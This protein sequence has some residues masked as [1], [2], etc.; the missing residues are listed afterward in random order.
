M[1]SKSKRRKGLKAKKYNLGGYLNPNGDPT[2]K[3]GQAVAESTAVP[4]YAEQAFL[5]YA[6]LLPQLQTPF[7]RDEGTIRPTPENEPSFLQSIWE[8]TPL[9]MTEDERFA[10]PDQMSLLDVMAEPMK[11]IEYYSIESNRGKL[12]TRAEWDLFGSSNPYDAALAMY[13]PAA[14]ISFAKEDE[15][16][17]L[18]AFTGIGK[19]GNVVRDAFNTGDDLLRISAENI[20]K[21]GQK[22][23]QRQLAQQINKSPVVDLEEAIYNPDVYGVETPGFGNRA[24]TFHYLGESSSPLSKQLQAYHGD[25]YKIDTEDFSIRTQDTFNRTN[26]GYGYSLPITRS[27]GYSGV[28]DDHMSPKYNSAVHD[29]GAYGMASIPQIKSLQRGGE[30]EKFIKKDG[31]INIDEVL[32]YVNST[33][34]ITPADKFVINQA[35][36]S[37]KWKRLWDGEGSQDNIDYGQFKRA[38]SEFVPR[39]A[40][41]VRGGYAGYGAENVFPYH[42]SSPEYPGYSPDK[43]IDSHVVVISEIDLPNKIESESGKQMNNYLLNGKGRHYGEID[44]K[45]GTTLGNHSHYR[46]SRLSD[47]PEISYFLEIQ[48][49]GLSP[50]GNSRYNLADRKARNAAKL[51]TNPDFEHYDYNGWTLDEEATFIGGKNVNLL[52]NNQYQTTLGAIASDMNMNA[53][54]WSDKFN[55]FLEELIIENPK[56]FEPILG[57]DISHIDESKLDSF[58]RHNIERVRNAI[59]IN[60]TAE[61]YNQL[62]KNSIEP[63]IIKGHSFLLSPEFGE[64]GKSELSYVVDDIYSRMNDMIKKY[65]SDSEFMSRVMSGEVNSSYALDDLKITNS[66]VARLFDDVFEPVDKARRY[67]EKKQRQIG[68]FRTEMG[69]FFEVYG[70]TMNNPILMGKQIPRGDVRELENIKNEIAQIFQEISKLHDDYSHMS[71]NLRKIQASL[72]IDEELIF[73]L[74]IETVGIDKEFKNV[75]NNVSDAADRAKNIRF[76]ELM[77]QTPDILGLIEKYN[78]LID[79]YKKE[80]K[81]FG[82]KHVSEVKSPYA[83]PVSQIM[84]KRPER[85]IIGEA[86]HGDFNNL[87]NRFPTEET[88]RKI[89]GH[90]AI[91][92]DGAEKYNDVHKKYRSMDKTLKAMGYEPKLVTDKYGNTWWEVKATAGMIHGTAEYDAYWKGGRI[93]LKK[94]RSRKMRSVKC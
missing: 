67:I 46:V 6:G 92:E 70:E 56:E 38:V 10:P 22:M 24:S 58:F 47:E 63:K 73:P 57:I 50:K 43:D 36:H 59:N 23:T 49:D 53:G 20:S 76:D 54:G 69:D 86:L 40:T 42:F 4:N 25:E 65:D 19:I 16:G 85:R 33:N 89:Q 18:S 29:Y 61:Q 8:G 72:D 82:E 93:G 32:S 94:K 81:I 62:Y 30:L 83:N 71:I 77:E 60:M 3:P 37:V 66:K 48:S 74:D 55:R 21:Q 9:G 78:S 39:M 5:N 12:P 27:V 80:I 45:G 68:D 84:K 52:R 31:T 75:L 14:Q 34:T 41:H 44:M 79:Q 2:K 90:P 11:A 1:K 91:G 87:Y 17:G 28:V 15:A 13:N 64:D 35:V 51:Y 7:F 88:S 26:D